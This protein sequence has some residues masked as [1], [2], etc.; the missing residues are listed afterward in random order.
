VKLDV[1]VEDRPVGVLEQVAIDKFVFTY[2]RD[3]DPTDAIS[4]LMPVRTESYTS[5]TLHPFFQIS[6]PEGVILGAL[7]RRL[8]RQKG[9]KVSEMDLL[10]AIGH[11]TVGRVR[12]IPSVADLP[13][14][15]EDHDVDFLLKQPPQ[16]LAQWFLEERLLKSGVSGAF[17]K[18]FAADSTPP[19]RRGTLRSDT[20]IIKFDDAKYPCIS[21]NEYWSMEVASRAGFNAARTVLSKD[22][23]S[24]AIE[25]FDRQANKPFLG[26][27]DF[28]ALTGRSAADKYAGSV[29]RIVKDIKVQV[30][31]EHVA[32]DLAAFFAAYLCCTTLRN[33]DAHTKNFGLLYPDPDSVRL[34]PI[35]DMVT[36]SMYA[37][38]D[39]KGDSSASMA[40]TFAGTR[41]WLT[42]DLIVKLGDLCGL[43]KRQRNTIEDA[44]SESMLSVARDMC[45]AASDHPEFRAAAQRMTQLW[46]HGARV[47]DIECADGLLEVCETT[48]APTPIAAAR[49]DAPMSFEDSEATEKSFRPG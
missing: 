32:A 33:D 19:D 23:R 49:E 20:W 40:L 3:T 43:T 1:Y 25:R 7:N 45:E 35:Y 6:L 17:P 38:P 11:N 4:L 39:N 46:S 24:L 5:K 9:G 13:G 30:R 27:E 15:S 37:P 12:V 22:M 21:F 29:E 10:E 28:C 8:A 48:E 26:F 36:S 41:K 47:F 14:E 31:P 34:A 16:F 44:L 42:S 2:L 18:G